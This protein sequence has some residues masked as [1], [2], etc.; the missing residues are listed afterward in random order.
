MTKNPRFQSGKDNPFETTAA[1]TV[2]IHLAQPKYQAVDAIRQYGPLSRARIAEAISYSPSKITSVVNDLIAANI[3]QEIGEGESTGGRRPR[4]VDFNPGYGYIVVATIGLTKLD[5]ALVDFAEHTRVRRMIPV[6]P[7]FASSVVLN[8]MTSFVL[9]RIDKLNI[10]ISDVLAF[11]IAVPTSVDRHTG[12]LFDT[13]IMPTSG[14]PQ[15]DS[16]VREIFP[17]VPIIVENDANVMA[18]GEVRKG[19][20]HNTGNMVYV[21][22]GT[23]ISA[24]FILDGQIYRGASGRAGDI[25][26]MYVELKNADGTVTDI[27]PLESIASGTS[28]AAQAVEMVEQGENTLLNNYD[29]ATLSARDVGE[30]A[31]AGDPLANEIVQRSGQVIGET[32]ANIVTFLDPDLILIGGGVSNIGPTLLTSIRRSILDRSPSLATQHLRIEIAPLGS[33]ASILGATALALENV[34]AMK[35]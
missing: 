8:Q 9:E 6:A 10:A 18:Y 5:V 16:F 19:S 30:A 29:L 17:Y 25:G 32:L 14:W 27:V 3:L 11:V 33:E 26:Q 31:A 13:P 22:V 1:R 15:I 4:D 7:Q 23:S 24:G 21:K 28:I 2:P 12:A 35:D 20:A 34:F